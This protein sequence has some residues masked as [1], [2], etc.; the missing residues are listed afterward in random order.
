MRQKDGSKTG[1]A[2]QGGAMLAVARVGFHVSDVSPSLTIII[3]I[4]MMQSIDYLSIHSILFISHFRLTFPPSMPP[5]RTQL[6]PEYSQQNGR[7]WMT[8]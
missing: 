3:L 5:H 1:V 2:A 8:L 4:L 6:H 7:Q